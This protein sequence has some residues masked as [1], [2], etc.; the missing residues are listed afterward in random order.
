MSELIGKY[1]GVELPPE[2]EWQKVADF[3]E[4]NCRMR[5]VFTQPSFVHKILEQCAYVIRQ[6]ATRTPD[7]SAKVDVWVSEKENDKSLRVGPKGN[8]VCWLSV[9]DYLAASMLCEAHNAA[10]QAPRS[11]TSATSDIMQGA[12]EALAFAKGEIQPSAIVHHFHDTSAVE[13]V[14]SL[15][16][17]IRG[18]T[19]FIEKHGMPSDAVL[20]LLHTAYEKQ[21]VAEQWL[22]K[23][24]E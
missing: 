7:T 13:L 9:D 19:M 12:R 18:L 3:C 5:T 11:D 20:N 16:A 23:A 17:G 10:L 1:T 4:M 14:R 21:E 2:N 22:K 24:G 8:P 6:Y 15:S